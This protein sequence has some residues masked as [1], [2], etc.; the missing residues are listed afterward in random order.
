MKLSEKGF[1]Q[2]S[3]SVLMNHYVRHEYAIQ[4]TPAYVETL[5]D[6]EILTELAT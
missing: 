6:K 5:R 4:H 3:E 2:R 1:E